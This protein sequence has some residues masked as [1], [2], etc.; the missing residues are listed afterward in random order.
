M[1]YILFR[2][3]VNIL[4]TLKKNN[5]YISKEINA[6]KHISDLEPK[7]IPNDMEST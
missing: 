5:I 1:L 3:N 6:R 2:P 7:A 4:H